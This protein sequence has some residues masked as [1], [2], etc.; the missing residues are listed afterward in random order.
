MK[1][2]TLLVSAILVAAFQADLLAEK[3]IL[4]SN[5]IA[6]V[7]D[8]PASIIANYIKA[9][10][11][12]AKVK[13]IIN[14]SMTAE[15]NFQGQIIEIKTIADSENSRMMQSTSVGGNVVQKT[16]LVNGSGQMVMMGQVQ[17]LPE[18]T[19]ALLKPQTYV[20]PE[21]FYTEMGFTLEFLGTEEIDGQQANKLGITAPNGMVTNE[22]Y[23]V[24]SGLKLRTSSAPTGEIS[25]SD[26]SEVEGVLF[27]MMLTIKN[28][29]LP[30]A[31]EAKIISVK[32]NQPLSDADFQ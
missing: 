19:V 5:P 14:A 24:E 7:N 28:P 26:Y 10:G 8:D 21:Q 17:E 3:I 16:L 13:A 32:F 27:P 23:S 1:I 20:F 9:V 29:M 30:V 12:E 6:T 25:Y 22:F 15:A 18:E 11:G 31:L 4:A 2:K